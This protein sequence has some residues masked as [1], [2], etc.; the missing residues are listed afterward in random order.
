MSEREPDYIVEWTN[1]SSEAN[2]V[3]Y[4]KCFRHGVG[5]V[6]AEYARRYGKHNV[7][8]FRITEEHFDYFP[9]RVEILAK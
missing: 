9:P 4:V 5:D 8:I 2:P 7:R 1:P 3:G 6:A